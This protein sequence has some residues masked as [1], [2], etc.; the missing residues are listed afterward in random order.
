MYNIIK[1]DVYIVSLYEQTKGDH[2]KSLVVH[3]IK[4]GPAVE[5]AKE[6]KETLEQTSL[7]VVPQP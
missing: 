4:R 7:R 3:Y 5:L 1:H 6:L 2:S